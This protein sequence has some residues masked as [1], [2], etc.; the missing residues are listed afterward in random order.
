MGEIIRVK[1]LDRQF[2]NEA[3]E[4]EV[5]IGTITRYV[6]NKSETY[7]LSIWLG[8]EYPYEPKPNEDNLRTDRRKFVNCNVQAYD[9]LEKIYE[10]RIKPIFEQDNITVIFYY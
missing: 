3:D 6:E 9:D 10:T 8:K 5:V 4:G 7:Y 1:A 2:F